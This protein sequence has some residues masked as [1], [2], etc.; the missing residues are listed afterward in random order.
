MSVTGKLWKILNEEQ[1][2][3]LLERLLKIRG[4]TSPEQEK[5]F[6][7]DTLALHDPFGLKDMKKAVERIKDAIN[8]QEKIIIFGDYDVDGISGASILVHTLE[9]LGAQ[10]SYRLPHRVN[11]GYGLTESFIEEFKKIGL[12][13]LITVDC[14]I[15]CKT[16]ISLAKEYGIDVIIT[17]HHTLPK[18]MPTDAYAILHPLQKDC[19]YIFPYLSGSGMALKLASALLKGFLS[20]EEY[21]KEIDTLCDL[22]CLGTVADLVPL[23]GENRTIVKRGLKGIRE[24]RWPGIQAI[25]EVGNIQTDMNYFD[26]DVIGYGIGPRINAAGRIDEPYIALQTLLGKKDPMKFAQKLEDLNVIRREMTFKAMQ[27]VSEI[28]EKLPVDAKIII[29]ESKDWHIGIVGLLAGKIA[30]QYKKPVIVM[31]NRGEELVGSARSPDFFSMVDALTQCSDL[32]ES[33][34]GHIQAA[35]FTVKKKNLAKLIEKLEKIAEDGLNLTQLK[36]VLEIDTISSLKEMD[37]SSLESV[38]KL[39]PFGVGNLKPKFLLKNLEVRNVYCIGADKK[40]LRFDVFEDVPDSKTGS[41]GLQVIG[42]NFGD[43]AKDLQDGRKIDMVV[44]LDSNTWNGDTF[45]QL[46]LIDFKI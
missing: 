14:G 8:T 18:A 24:G 9:R 29:L 10:V 25:K 30:E 42:F 41:K 7:Y 45:L 32:L 21:E 6:L 19:N 35:G 44:H 39:S 27:E 5:E 43:Y 46:R 3:S 23:H 40:H 22:A 36:Q 2:G 16:Q 11:D 26:A 31:E 38:W 15:S 34:G 4:I 17:D 33:F 12:R 37:W 1:S 20:A 13:L 28:V